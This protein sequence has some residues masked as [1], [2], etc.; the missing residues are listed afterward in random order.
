VSTPSSTDPPPAAPTTRLGPIPGFTRPPRGRRWYRRW[1]LVILV[2]LAALAAAVISDIPTPQST[3]QQASVVSGVVKE[4]ATGVHPCAYAVSEAFRTFYVPSTDGTLTKTSRGFANQYLDQDQQACSFESTSIF[5]MS[6]ITVPNSPA[7]ARLTD[8]IKTALEWA[9]S[10]ANG[11]IV[12]IQALVRRPTDT[13]ALENLH[14]R[15]RSLATD[16]RKAE[17]DL[18]DA[19]TDLHGQLLPGLGLPAFPDPPSASST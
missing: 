10:D 16:R 9:T 4:I 7:G 3:R 6:T 5:S 13:K 12:D 2:L 15:E 1:T 8:I 11:A 18:R 17:G 19:E 14:A